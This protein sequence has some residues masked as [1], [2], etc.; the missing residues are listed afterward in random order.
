MTKTSARG[1]LVPEPS[2]TDR[3]SHFVDCE[4]DILSVFLHIM[5]ET[6]ARDTGADGDNFESF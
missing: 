6:D 5:G 1:L 3:G 2:A 4:V